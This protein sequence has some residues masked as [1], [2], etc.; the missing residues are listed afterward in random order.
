MKILTLLI[1]S[2]GFLASCGPAG[3]SQRT[4][5]EIWKL[6]WRM[7]ESS[8][9]ENFVLADKQFDS[10]RNISP[11]L[12]LQYLVVGLKVKNKLGKSGEI[13]TLLNA[14][15]EAALQEIC[16]KQFSP[17]LPSCASTPAPAVENQELQA[18]LIRMYVADQAARGN[19]VQDIIEKYQIDPASVTP[20]VGVTVDEQNRNRLKEIFQQHGF[21]TKQLVGRDAMQGVFL[22]IQHSDEDKEWQQAQLSNVESAVKN[23]DMDGQSFA[24]LYDRIKMNN[25]ENQL[26][27]TQFSKVDPVNKTVE[28]AKTDDV[29]N[30]DKRRR[31]IG[32]MPIE[33]YKRLVL[34]DL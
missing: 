12:D 18:E 14:Q 5:E 22:M 23:G 30:L 27:G 13:A 10:L 16:A 17:E 25:G 28:L 26:Y 21:P 15:E 24:Y 7:I 29:E 4:E 9:E 11:Q 6:G 34:Q 33:M 3:P 31:E 2:L 20:G 1:A 19:I 8:I 32:M